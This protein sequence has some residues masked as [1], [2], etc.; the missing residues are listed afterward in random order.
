MIK[1]ETNNEDDEFQIAIIPKG[2]PSQSQMEV[3]AKKF[4]DLLKKGVKP[5]DAAEACGTNLKQ[6]MR[7]EDVKEIIEHNLKTYTFSAEIDKLLVRA[8]RRKVLV[9]NMQRDDKDSSKLV[10][11]AARDIAGDPA[12][13]LTQQQ[14]ATLIVDVSALK[15]LFEEKLDLPY[16]DVEVVEDEKK[17]EIK[18]GKN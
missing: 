16:I 13:G 8:G 17:E 15:K 2:K 5:G 10:L 11:E 9:E 14:S 7:R 18:D 4:T 1:E 6:I 3:Q 12:V